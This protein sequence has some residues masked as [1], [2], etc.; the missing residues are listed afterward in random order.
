M[1]LFLTQLLNGLVYGVLLFLV[2]AGLALIFGLLGI[3]NLAHGSFFML[4]GFVALS[5][6]AA[7]GCF[8]L[9]LLLA[10]VPIMLVAGLIE[11][12]FLR[13]LYKRA[14]LDLVL[15]TFGLSF[16]LT[17][18]TETIWGKELASL[19][20]PHGLDGPVA[21]L[22]NAFPAY[23]LA[24]LG[25]GFAC[26][27]A[28]WLVLERTRAGSM[29]RAGVDDAQTAMNIG[30]NVPRLRTITFA[31]GAGLAALA[32]VIAGPILGVFSGVDVE[33]LIP[34]FIVVSIG[35][36]G[37]LRGALVGSLVIGFADTLGKA[38]LPSLSM[39]LVYL[40]MIGILL[41]RP[42]GL[43]GSDPAGG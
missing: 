3:V 8:W 39:F 22:G 33:V 28:M 20:E 13:R 35:G 27:V 42:H 38:Y 24:L 12:V 43:F 15:L 41:V 23:R 36:L 18:I 7:T 19:A 16:I 14:P 5:I 4:G 17:D 26:A 25:F 1:D 37:S 21:I 34:A 6:A 9:A 10:P 29:V 2:A 32:G 31:L 40:A 11:V 30:L